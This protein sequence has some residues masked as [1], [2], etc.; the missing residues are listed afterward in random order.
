MHNVALS[1]SDFRGKAPPPPLY[2]QLTAPGKKS[3][4]FAERENLIQSDET[5]TE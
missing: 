2:L 4:A 1:Y 3:R 5:Y